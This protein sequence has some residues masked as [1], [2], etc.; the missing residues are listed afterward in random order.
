MVNTSVAGLGVL[1]S[2][3]HSIYRIWRSHT[4]CATKRMAG[5]LRSA[6]SATGTCACRIA[7]L[8]RLARGHII[9]RELSNLRDDEA[10]PLR[11][12]RLRHLSPPQAADS[13]YRELACVEAFL[14]SG[15]CEGI[16]P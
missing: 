16:T 4:N 10:R 12:H 9:F 8:T 6:L 11:S 2:F 15:R 1:D 14:L 3:E 7:R 5:K 13:F